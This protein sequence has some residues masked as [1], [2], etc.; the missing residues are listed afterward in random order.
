MKNLLTLCILC[1]ALSCATE[2]TTST[3]Q[4]IPEPIPVADPT[5]PAPTID[6]DTSVFNITYLTGK[7][8]PTK[9]PNFTK[10]A[11][12][13]TDGDPYVLHEETY[14]A[15][16]QMHAAAKADG[17]KLT[18]VSATRNFN[19][20]KFIWEAKWTGKRLV[21]EGENLAETTPDPK[22]RALRILRWS[23]MPG[24]SRHHWGTDI[25][26]NALNNKYFESGRG[27]A[28]YEW[29]VANGPRFG[30]CQPY[31][32]KGENGRPHGYN[33]EKWHWSYLPL[34]KQLTYLAQTQLQDSQINGF[35]G[36]ETAPQIG[37]V[38]KY[39]LGINPDCL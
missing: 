16:E 28:E 13:Y 37:V 11:A 35:E 27:L 3:Q 1:L 21:E 15:F 31:S 5:P 29:L 12:E 18:M 20:Q 10:V 38:E 9:H 30:F 7:F 24:T 17:I 6:V 26:L 32:P 23:S 4:L 33:E 8:D 19:R 39:V 34:A 22:A 2:P 14:A 25:D 36:A